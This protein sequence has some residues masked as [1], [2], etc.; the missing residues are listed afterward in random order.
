MCR[1]LRQYSDDIAQKDALPVHAGDRVPDSGGSQ[2]ANGIPPK[3]TG[4]NPP[5]G[6]VIYYFL[7][8]AP[9]A[10]TEAKIEILDASGKVI[11]KYSSTEYQ[12]A[13]RASRPGRQEAGE[14]DQAG[15]GLEPVRVGFAV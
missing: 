4:Q 15:S 7:K 3:V 12:H 14:G 5:A 11:R 2:Q 8:D 9:K 6:A 10:D 13:G 1:P